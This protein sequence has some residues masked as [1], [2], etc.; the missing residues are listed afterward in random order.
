MNIL[1]ETDFEKTCGKMMPL[2]RD[3]STFNGD[4]F[5]C[6][7]GKEHTFYTYSIKV[8]SEGFNG[9]FLVVCP[10][11]QNLL[12]LIKTKMRFGIMY[13]GLELLAGHEIGE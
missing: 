3:M 5:R 12:S 4:N 13:Q 11:H 9:K 10:D 7:C 2:R 8:L 6:A 1:S